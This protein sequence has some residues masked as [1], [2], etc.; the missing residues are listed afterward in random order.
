MKELLA[1]KELRREV[2]IWERSDSCVA[3]VVRVERWL[4]RE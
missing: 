3:R 2:D 1:E 4:R